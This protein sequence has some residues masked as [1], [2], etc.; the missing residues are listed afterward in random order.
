MR[1][2][3]GDWSAIEFSR[4]FYLA[5]AAC[6]PIESAFEIGVAQLMMMSEG[7]DYDVPLLLGGSVR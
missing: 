7:D 2:P 5:L 1:Q 6:S 4:G 3:I